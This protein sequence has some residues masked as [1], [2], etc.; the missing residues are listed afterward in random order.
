MLNCQT[1]SQPPEKLV[2]CRWR[3]CGGSLKLTSLC[4]IAITTL[5]LA[6][7][8][9]RPELSCV[10]LWGALVT[11]TCKHVVLKL[12]HICTRFC[13][14]QIPEAR[15]LSWIFLQ[16]KWVRQFQ[17]CYFPS[18]PFLL[19]GQGV[20]CS[21]SCVGF[22][23]FTS[24]PFLHGLIWSPAPCD[25]ACGGVSGFEERVGCTGSYSSW[26]STPSGGGSRSATEMVNHQL[27]MI[28]NTLFPYLRLLSWQ[29]GEHL[30]LLW[31][32][33]HVYGVYTSQSRHVVLFEVW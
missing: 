25:V 33:N 22:S 27:T 19:V 32:S 3:R 30:Q 28:S 31:N 15:Q 1:T 7:Q 8:G 11:I 2:R 6:W 29:R 26:T 17:L 23:L 10:C 20:P 16:C 18:E 12:A 24:L 21:G 5:Y 9:K 14:P 4:F 13:P